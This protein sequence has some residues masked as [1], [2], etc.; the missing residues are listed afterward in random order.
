MNEKNELDKN[1]I[2]TNKIFEKKD[3]LVKDLLVK[4]EVENLP[5]VYLKYMKNMNGICTFDELFS[6]NNYFL[7][8][9]IIRDCTPINEIIVLKLYNNI[10]RG[11]YKSL[12][13]KKQINLRHKSYLKRNGG[14]RAENC[15]VNEDGLVYLLNY[16]FKNKIIPKSVG[17]IDLM[18]RL[19]IEGKE[20]DKFMRL[21]RK[22]INNGRIFAIINNETP[23]R[24]LKVRK[25]IKDKEEIA[26]KQN[27]I[28]NNI[29]NNTKN[30][31]KIPKSAPS[32]IENSEISLKNIDTTNENSDGNYN[33]E[34]REKVAGS[35]YEA[36]KIV[37]T[38]KFMHP[39]NRALRIE[40]FMTI[41]LG[42]I[43]IITLYLGLKKLFI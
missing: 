37:Y 19:N 11:L 43:I 33:E 22:I 38:G 27:N 30:N 21:L 28:K 41:L 26:L 23:L 8:N 18:K 14:Y 7:P 1:D 32:N 12:L 42:G 34:N 9:N 39:T 3:L 16:L 17:A 25:I 2:F 10:I 35:N 24:P 13:E 4:C 31:I 36:I 20:R 6:F 15:L 29:K 5:L 40:L